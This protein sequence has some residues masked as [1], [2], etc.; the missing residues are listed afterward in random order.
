MISSENDI[1]ALQSLVDQLSA[2][3]TKI[4]IPF[5]SNINNTMRTA[6][7]EEIMRTEIIVKLS[8][9]FTQVPSSD[10]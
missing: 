6:G 5:L 1:V 9:L 7:L 2:T 3:L 10:V 4:V 8:D